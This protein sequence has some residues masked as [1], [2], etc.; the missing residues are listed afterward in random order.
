MARQKP[1]SGGTVYLVPPNIAPG[2]IPI[3]RPIANTQIYLLGRQPQARSHR[4]LWGKFILVVM[5]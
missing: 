2:S 1:Q 4:G 3:G 5:G